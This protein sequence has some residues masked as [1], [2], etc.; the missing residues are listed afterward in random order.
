ALFWGERRGLSF[1]IKKFAKPKY[2]LYE[3]TLYVIYPLVDINYKKKVL[4]RLD[5]INNKSYIC[6]R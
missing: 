4:K 6:T 3:L 5:Y 1:K 2:Q